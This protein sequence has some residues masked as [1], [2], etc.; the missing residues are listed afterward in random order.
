[1]TFITTNILMYYACLRF[2]TIY[3]AYM[4]CFEVPGSLFSVSLMYCTFYCGLFVRFLN[5]TKRKVHLLITTS[6]HNTFSE[7]LPV[8]SGV[9]WKCPDLPALVSLL[10]CSW[11]AAAAQLSAVNNWLQLFWGNTV[12]VQTSDHTV[13]QLTDSDHYCC[14]VPLS[15]R[16]IHNVV[17]C[18][19]VG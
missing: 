15:P 7:T 6:H 14:S 13:P 19:K 12:T 8:H 9:R 18:L 2:K 11:Q 5:L 3:R 10:L 1:M 17:F 16:A 4:F